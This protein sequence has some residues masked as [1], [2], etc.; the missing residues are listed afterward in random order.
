ML[1]GRANVQYD[2]HIGDARS[3]R[4]NAKM[5]TLTPGELAVMRLLWQH[6]EMK[7]AEIQ[8]LFPEP[9][10]NP[11]LRSYLTILLDKGHVARRKAGKVYFYKAVTRQ[12]SAFRSALRDVV[13]NWCEGSVK[14]LMLGVIRTEKLSADDLAE[15][16]RV[17]TEKPAASSK[18]TKS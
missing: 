4:G 11:A 2:L 14:A 8:K 6:G 1:D 16:Q 5:P 13:D 17:V 7:P 15:L 10:K 12:T 18:R 9:I 3:P